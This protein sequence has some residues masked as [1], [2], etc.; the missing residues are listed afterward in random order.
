MLF[1]GGILA[2]SHGETK[3]AGMGRPSI[4]LTKLSVNAHLVGNNAGRDENQKLA[5]LPL[6]GLHLEQPAQEGYIPKERDLFHRV[7]GL[8]HEHPTNNHRSTIFHQYICLDDRT[9]DRR[10]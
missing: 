7:F 6:V 4:G 5:T 2:D 8:G 9:L 10:I 1:H 3:K